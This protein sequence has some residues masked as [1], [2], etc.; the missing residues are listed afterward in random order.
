MNLEEVKKLNIPKTPGSY[1]FYDQAGKV[2][3]VG[4]A[5]N[6]RSR[7]F[8]YWQKSANHSPAKYSMM[9]QIERVK[10]IET[11]SE[12]EALLLEGNL[13]KRLQPQ[14]NVDRRDDK[15]P[16]YIKI[17]T[18]A[19]IPSV[20]TTRKLD[21]TGKYFGPYTSVAAVKE[22]LKAVRKIWPYCTQKKISDKPCFYYQINRCLGI[23]GGL[24]SRKEYQERVIRPII[25]FLE[26]R[27]KEIIKE[28]TKE[29]RN[30]K[31][32]IGKTDKFSPK[33]EKIAIKLND[34][35]FKL[36]NMKYV[37]EHTKIVSLGEKYATDVVELAKVLH[38]PK[39]PERIEGYDISNIF[40]SEAVGA[41]VVFNDGE[42]NKNEY[43]KFK[44]KLGQGLANDVRM[45]REVLERRFKNTW[46]LPDLIIVD[47]GKAQR[48]TATSVLKKYGL[49]IPILAVSKGS[50]LRSAKARD[51]I[52]W[53]G[54]KEALELPLASPALHVIKRVRDEAHRF[55]ISYHRLLRKK[56]AFK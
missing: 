30:W 4:K 36:S 6:L 51:K 49:E 39:V 34:A 44:I 48:N 10:W 5:S 28:M 17:D 20:T 54:E 43:R 42:P 15:R 9:K 46:S 23:C 29:I 22:T 50:G 47:G 38:L 21:K 7:V 45:L 55:A 24:V 8:S 16:L 26:G 40:G 19:E 14:Y 37:L 52:F 41:M 12:I 25:M 27:K 31:L 56:R 2:L 1:Q 32:E 35:E 33:Y 53:P 18:Y 3:Y 13:I 11:E